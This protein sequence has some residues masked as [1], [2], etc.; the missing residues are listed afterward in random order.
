[1]KSKEVFYV[2]Y[3]EHCSPKIRSFESECEAYRFVGAFKLTHQHKYNEE[4]NWVDMVFAGRIMFTNTTIEE[5]H[6][7][8]R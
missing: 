1:M 7:K 4:D 6:V 3:T 5:S 2:Q 8:T